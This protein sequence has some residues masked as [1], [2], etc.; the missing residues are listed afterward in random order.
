MAFLVNHF[1]HM[2]EVAPTRC[3]GLVHGGWRLNDG[4]ASGKQ[5]AG[6]LPDDTLEQQADQGGIYDS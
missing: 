3:G 2:W 5:V 6:K 1:A 4:S